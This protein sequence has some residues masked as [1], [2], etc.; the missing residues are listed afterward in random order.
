MKKVFAVF[1]FV[2]SIAPCVLSAT[3][4][5]VFTVEPSDASI[6]VNGQYYGTGTATVVLRQAGKV[7]VS[8]EREGYL[9]LVRKYQYNFKFGYNSG[10]ETYNKGKNYFSITLQ[11]DSRYIP[12]EA[13]CSRSDSVN[14]YYSCEVRPMHSAESAWKEIGN[15]V[16]DYFEDMDFNGMEHGN[17]KTPWA[18]AYAGGKKIRT[19][20]IVRIETETPLTYKFNLQ[21]EYCN[22]LNAYEY[23]DYRFQRWDMVM[24]K[25]EGLINALFLR[26]GGR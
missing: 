20:L 21:S 3:F 5:L 1:V 9:T 17:L 14:T 11:K 26:V 10:S 25:Y 22:D 12:A 19:R 23:D 16:L 6:T 18:T 4:T 24:N 13:V 8:F 15:V 7:V 2:F